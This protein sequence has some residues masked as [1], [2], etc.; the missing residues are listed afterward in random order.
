MTLLL[1]WAQAQPPPQMMPEG[2]EWWRG[3]LALLIVAGLLG[4]LVV[5]LRRGALGPLG[6]RRSGGITIDAVVPLGDRR[7]LVVVT[8]EGRRL[9]LGA[10]PVNVTL[11]TELGPAAGFDAVLSSE[12]RRGVEGAR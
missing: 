5:L 10:S 8:V 3:M 11:V 2:M 1:L 7:T 4:A 12:V 6:R 9:L